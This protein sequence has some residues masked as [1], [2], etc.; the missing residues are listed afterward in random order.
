MSH[1]SALSFL[2]LEW[3]LAKR[4]EPRHTQIDLRWRMVYQAR[5]QEKTYREIAANLNVDHS[6]VCRTVTL[7]KLVMLILGNTHQMLALQG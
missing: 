3:R 2:E 1:R 6:T 7:M 5:V 4:K